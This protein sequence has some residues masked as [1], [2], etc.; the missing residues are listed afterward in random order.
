MGTPSAAASINPP[1][2]MDAA[3]PRISVPTMS[4][5]MAKAAPKQADAATPV[6]T[7]ATAM[8]A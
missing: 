6:M 8:T 7:R 3:R 1:K 5:Q 2:T 4:A